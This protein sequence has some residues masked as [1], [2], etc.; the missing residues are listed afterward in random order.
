MI[1]KCQ[2]RM[3]FIFWNGYESRKS[4]QRLSFLTS[5]EKFEYAY[6]AVQN[7]AANY[8]LKPIDMNKIN[9]ALLRVTEKIAWKQKRRKSGNIGRSEKERYDISGQ[10][11][12]WNPVCKNRDSR[13]K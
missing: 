4:R 7:G 12:C 13:R 8:L 2:R 9:Q 5:H 11:Y 10:E 6:G 1:L 3:E